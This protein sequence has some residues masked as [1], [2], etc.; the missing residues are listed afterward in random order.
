MP[1]VSVCVPVSRLDTVNF[2]I[3]SIIHQSFQ[4]WELI[5]VGQGDCDIPKVKKI[6]NLV[7]KISEKD[8]RVKYI[9]IKEA[10]ACRAKNASIRTAQ[11]EIIAEI[12]DDA[13]ADQDWL[14]TMVAYF[15]AHQDVDVVGG[16]VIKPP[17][18]KRGLAVCPHVEPSEKIYDPAVMDR[19]PEGWN[20]ISCNL[21]LRKKVF[22]RIGYYDEY[23]GPGSVF[24]AADDT[25]LLLRIEAAG[26]KMGSTPRLVVNHT[27][28]YRYGYKSFMKH[29]YNYSYGNG[30]LAAKQTLA[31]DPR[32]EEWYRYALKVRLQSWRKP[33]RPDRFV[34]GLYGWRIFNA[35]YQH[36]LNEFRVENN[37]LVPAGI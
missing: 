7:R 24:P 15:R 16:A 4:D 22:E 2:T 21:G 6:A 8:P 33:F 26:I 11:G 1:Q 17:K 25:D 20:W 37:L 9:H 12:D 5:A 29:Q 27:Y 19:P 28:G 23:L 32:G 14:D 35:A 18:E 30:G 34:R 10:G 36:C 31:G 3:Q 13:E